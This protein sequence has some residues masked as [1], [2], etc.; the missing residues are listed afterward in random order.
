MAF[1]RT[2]SVMYV[3]SPSVSTII[4]AEVKRGGAKLQHKLIFIEEKAAMVDR[5]L[6]AKRVRG[7]RS[8]SRLVVAGGSGAAATSHG[9]A[10]SSPKRRRPSSESGGSWSPPLAMSTTNPPINTADFLDESL[11]GAGGGFAERP[12]EGTGAAVAI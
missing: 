11:A 7:D 12:M 8:S 1:T 5:R 4:T 3:Y 9:A 6:H 2:Q 10:P